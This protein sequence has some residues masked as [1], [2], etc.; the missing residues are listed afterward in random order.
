LQLSETLLAEAQ[1]LSHT[2]SFGWNVSTDEI[3][4][5][6]ETYRIFDYEPGTNITIDMALG[7]VHPD[8]RAKVE[9]A[10]ERAKTQKETFDLE[11]RLQLPDGAVKNLHVVAHALVDEPQKLQ[12]AGA[13]MDITA[14]KQADQALRQSETRYQNLFQAMAVSFFE[15]D[16]TSSRQMLREVRNA[17]IT[18]FRRYFKENPDFI[19][20]IMQATHIVDVNDQTVALFGRGSKDE[21]L[22]SVEPFWPEES[23]QDY[24]ESVLASIERNQ[25]FSVETRMRRLDGTIFD[26]HFTLRYASEDRTRGVAGVIDIIPAVERLDSCC[27]SA[28]PRA[29][30][31]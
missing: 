14:R 1:K 16:Y 30:S 17:G 12:L 29:W 8:D 20:E 27:P 26:A 5:S 31:L 15:V 9:Q 3:F 22:T 4:W 24:V 23:Y 25:E 2:G 11:H 19:R 6:E 7:R 10:M 21:F 28:I 18:N 13:V